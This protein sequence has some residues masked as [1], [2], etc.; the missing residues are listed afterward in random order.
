MPLHLWTFELVNDFLSFG[1]PE[2]DQIEY[3]GD[4][5]Q[6]EQFADTLG[7]MANGDGGWIFVGV[8]ED[9]A[10]K[11]PKRWPLLAP[12]RDHTRDIFNLATA[13]V[14]PLIRPRVILMSDQRTESRFLWCAWIRVTTRRM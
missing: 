14:T 1:R 10:T 4:L 6:R 7:S 3:K 12:G 2:D 13:H 11:K 9:S 5:T 8:A